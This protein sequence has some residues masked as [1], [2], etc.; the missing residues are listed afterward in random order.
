MYGI[1]DNIDSWDFTEFNDDK[2]VWSVTLFD[3]KG[4]TLFSE[5]RF[6]DMPVHPRYDHHTKYVIDNALEY[7]DEGKPLLCTMYDGL[8]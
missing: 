6:G 7:L 5:Y 1:E 4:D 3:K 2:R 8:S